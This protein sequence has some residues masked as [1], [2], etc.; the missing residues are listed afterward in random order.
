MTGVVWNPYSVYDR[1]PLWAQL[2][3]PHENTISHTSPALL[4]VFSQPPMGHLWAAHGPP[5]GLSRTALEL[6]MGWPMP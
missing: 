4:A 2:Q 5:V 6:P 3:D 1:L